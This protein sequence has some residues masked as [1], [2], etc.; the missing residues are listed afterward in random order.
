MGREVSHPRKRTANINKELGF[1]IQVSE[2]PVIKN[3]I[4]KTFT[5]GHKETRYLIQ[6]R[7]CKKNN[8]A[9]S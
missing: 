1:W 8:T 5:I 2:K 4:I 3:T 7:K 6:W 9:I